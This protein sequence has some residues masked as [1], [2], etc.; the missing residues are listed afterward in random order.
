MGG[1]SKPLYELAGK[2]VLL[3]SL[4]VFEKSDYVKQVVLSA[5]RDDYNEIDTLV[6]R[7]NI[8][9]AH[10]IT[11]G[12]A[13]RQESVLKAFKSVFQRKE[14]ITPFIA[15][16]DAA[17]PLIS[18]EQFDEAVRT[19]MQYGSAVCAAKVRD[20]MQRTD[21]KGF[22]T[23]TVERENLWQIQTPQVF[24]TDL[25]HTALSVAERDGFEATDESGLLTNAGFKVKLF[26]CSYENMKLTYPEDIKIAEA[27]LK[28]REQDSTR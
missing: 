24:D 13:T 10:K 3:Y 4:E 6:S 12:G 9:K 20:T 15:I 2:K 26:E 16:H 17:R 18:V 19:A 14:D 7:N 23:E 28:M 27:I 1:V 22:V 21:K 25:F 5:R 11:E 8:H